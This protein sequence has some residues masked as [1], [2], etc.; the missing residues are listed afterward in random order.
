MA[1]TVKIKF[2]DPEQ[3]KIYRDQ[4]AEITVAK[5]AM[6]KQIYCS[7]EEFYCLRLFVAAT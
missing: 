1:S 5:S 2:H 4:G 3:T 6:T 7:T